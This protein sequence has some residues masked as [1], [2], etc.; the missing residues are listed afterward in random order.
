M[1][2]LI[3]ISLSIFL[4][5]SC[6]KNNPDPSWLEVNE[7]T[8]ESNTNSQYPTGELTHNFTDAWV[9]I[10]DKLIGVFEVPFKI[11]LLVSGDVNIKL[12]PTIKN[13]GISATKKIYPF[14]NVFE[15]NTTLVKNQTL[16]LNPKTQYYDYTQFW[17]EDFE[18]AAVKIVN[19]PNSQTSLMTGNNPAILKYGNF[20]GEVNLNAIDSTW[21][22]YT[23]QMTLP[24]GKEV[25]LEIDFYSTNYVTTGLIAITSSSVVNNE[26][27]RLIKQDDPTTIKWK[28]AYIDLKEIITNSPASANF[29]VSFQSLLDIGDT[30][31]Q[32]VLDNI[33]IVHF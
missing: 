17:I 24:R 30:E 1:K 25:Y 5:S 29:S 23:E 6:V 31:G 12:Y 32:I 4:F 15:V 26:Y 16:T 11:P 20:Y 8:L 33:K 7:W 21:V 22:A 9:F 3:Y 19:D 13:N 27:I 10:D 14:V 2:I 28:K 18:D